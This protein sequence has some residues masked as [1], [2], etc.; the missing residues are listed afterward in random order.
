[1]LAGKYG[2]G[3]RAMTRQSEMRT[4]THASAVSLFGRRH[5]AFLG[6]TWAGS[7]VLAS[8]FLGCLSPTIPLPPPDEPTIVA[9]NKAN[10]VLL[11][12]RNATPGAFIVA[13][14]QSPGV[15]LSLRVSGAQVDAAGAWTFEMAYGQLGE[16]ATLFQDLNDERSN[17]RQFV[18]KPT[19]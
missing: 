8:A 9:T 17:P 11:S 14:N 19:R 10:I 6:F 12:G 18:V 1:M 16:L 4:R 2:D 15:P 3:A 13:Y 7:V 5:V